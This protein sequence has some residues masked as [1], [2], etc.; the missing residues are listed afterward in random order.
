MTNTAPKPPMTNT[1]PIEL[2]QLFRFWR[3]LPHQTAAV[4][5]LQEAFK[6]PGATY[7][8]VMRRDQPWFKTWSTDGKQS[9]SSL[10]NLQSWLTFLCGPD[11]ERISRGKIKP[12]TPAEA[13][14][15]I[16]CII[17]ETGRPLLDKLDVI[18]AGSG[19]GRGAMQYTGVRRTAYDKARATAIAGG[20]DPNSNRWQQQ[21]FAEEYAGLHDPPQGS[22]IGWTR[23]FETRPAGMTA[24]SAAEYWT[25]S[26]AAAEGYFRPGVPHL[27]RRQQEANR[28]WDQYRAGKLTAAP[29]LQQPE[30]NPPTTAERTQWVTAVKALNLSQPDEVT[31]QSACIAMA[32][33]DRDIAKIR[34]ELTGRGDAGNPAVMAQV[35]RNYGRPYIYDGN[36]SM[37]KIYQ[38]L[39]AGE[40]LITHGWFTGSG[41]VI[42]LDGLKRQGT[43]YELDVKD[44][45][46][47]FNEAAWAYNLG[48]KFYDGFYSDRCIYAA[49]CAGA[50]VT[51]AK[52]IYQ[53]GRVDTA[54][55]GM[56]VH[57]FLTS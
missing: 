21:Y 10:A 2:E 37:A 29:Q 15:F 55:G 39:Q 50:S 45:W 41:H 23:I 9:D 20:I 19:A 11:V 13:C 26:A 8:T 48:S 4:S 49:C 42:C 34:R 6:Q 40:F 22:L 43:G 31:C 46:S 12:L 38:W 54:K 1:A 3:G 57:R 18:E 51:D 17:V 56:W 36:G 14:G 27:E 5:E 47:Q 28:V 25:G 24:A 16:G 32:V 7:A 30:L 33:G 44:P 52:R 53:T 35:I